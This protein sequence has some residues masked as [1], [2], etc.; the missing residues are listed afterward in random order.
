M[1]QYT[2]LGD[3][4]HLPSLWYEY[5]QRAKVDGVP[6][7]HSASWTRSPT[8]WPSFTTIWDGAM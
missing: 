8:I 3:I 5:R 7:A 1:L 4:V 6:K 2:W